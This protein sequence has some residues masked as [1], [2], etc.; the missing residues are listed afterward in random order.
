[1]SESTR[2]CTFENSALERL[3]DA[4]DIPILGAY[5]PIWVWQPRR[6]GFRFVTWRFIVGSRREPSLE[7]HSRSG[8]GTAALD[9]ARQKRCAGGGA[10]KLRSP[11]REGRTTVR[12]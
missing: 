4:G 2:C 1:M 3:I 7:R 10:E 6:R 9:T 12:R 8:P 11:A 5:Y